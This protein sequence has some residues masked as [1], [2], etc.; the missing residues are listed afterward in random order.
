MTVGFAVTYLCVILLQMH[1]IYY[2]ANELQLESM[3]I[4]KS[5]FQSNWYEQSSSCK[6]SFLIMM[7][8]SQKP[9]EIHIGNLTT[10]TADLIVKLAL[11]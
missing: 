1:F 9:L 10:V 5:I 7:M 3:D 8:R 2:Y 11:K 6:K 4:G